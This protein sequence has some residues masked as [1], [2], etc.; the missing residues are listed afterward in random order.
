[1]FNRPH[2]RMR[3]LYCACGGHWADWLTSAQMCG[4]EAR[5]KRLHSAPGCKLISKYDWERL[6]KGLEDGKQTT[7]G[8]AH[9]TGS[10]QASTEDGGRQK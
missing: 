9:S 7:E 4:F 8:T 5:F 1:M 2:G 3:H 10:G 6:G